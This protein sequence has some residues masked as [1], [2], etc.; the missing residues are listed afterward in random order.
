MEVKVEPGYGPLLEA[1]VDALEQSQHGKGRERHATDLPFLQQPIMVIARR[2][3]HGYTQGQVWKKIE[4]VGNIP[5]LD[6][7]IDEMLS[8]INYAAG[9]VILMREQKLKSRG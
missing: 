9:T 5:T 8:I 6:K 7:K 1:L 3:G 4:E 2:K